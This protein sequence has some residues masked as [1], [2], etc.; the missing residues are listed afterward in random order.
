M[1]WRIPERQLCQGAINVLP[2]D[3]EGGYM[4]VFKL[5]KITCILVVCALLHM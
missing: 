4:A 1:M 3:L 2:L 5:K